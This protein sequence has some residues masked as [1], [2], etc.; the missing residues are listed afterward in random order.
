VELSED[1]LD[2]VSFFDPFDSIHHPQFKMYLW[3]ALIQ[4]LIDQL[5]HREM[6]IDTRAYSLFW[7]NDRGIPTFEAPQTTTRAEWQFISAQSSGC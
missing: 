6:E 7:C 2:S 3:T 5:L 1:E 4:V